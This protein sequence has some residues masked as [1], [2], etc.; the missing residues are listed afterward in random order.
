MAKLTNRMK[1]DKLSATRRIGDEEKMHECVTPV[2]ECRHGH[3]VTISPQ[4]VLY[5]AHRRDANEL[6]RSLIFDQF[7]PRHPFLFP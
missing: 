1:R 3:T 6:L 4:M 5:R 2:N 7:S